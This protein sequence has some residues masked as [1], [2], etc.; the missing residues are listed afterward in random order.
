LGKKYKAAIDEKRVIRKLIFFYPSIH[1]TSL[2]LRRTLRAN[3]SR[4]NAFF[5][6]NS[7]KVNLLI[8]P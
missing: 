3:G 1:S 8:Q 2:T 4:N 5:K 6:S 7:H